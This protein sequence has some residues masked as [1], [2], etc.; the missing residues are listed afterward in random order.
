M[1]QKK[2]VENRGGLRLGSGQKKKYGEETETVSFRC[3]ISKIDELKF[4]LRAKLSECSIKQHLTDK[5]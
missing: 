5:P 2:K 4:L 1:K 3:P